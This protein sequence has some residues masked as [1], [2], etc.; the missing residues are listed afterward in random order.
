MD[1]SLGTV[2]FAKVKP[3]IFDH[4]EQETIS[5]GDPESYTWMFEKDLEME[6]ISNKD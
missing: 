1:G 3:D 4:Y 5:L 2:S 6:F